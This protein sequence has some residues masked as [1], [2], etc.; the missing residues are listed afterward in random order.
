[1]F[2]PYINRFVQPDS[3]IPDLSNPQSWN[4]YSYVLNTPINASDPT[5]HRCSGDVDE[6]FDY[7]G[8]AIN[9]ANDTE[10]QNERKKQNFLFQQIF[11]GSGPNGIWTTSDWDRYYANRADFWEN[12]ELWDP[13]GP[14]GWA[15]F[16]LQ[17]ERL[18]SYYRPEQ[19]DQFVRDFGLVF[20]GIPSS[21][22]FVSAALSVRYGPSDLQHLAYTNDGLPKSLWDND[23]T[24]DQAHHYAGIFVLGYFTEPNSASFVNT[25][26]DLGNPG[27]IALGNFAAGSG[28]AYSLGGDLS[29]IGNLISA[30]PLYG[31]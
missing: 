6:C 24:L 2:S 15:L 26:R 25:M 3:I 20:A 23:P 5:G 17:A 9:G 18:S 1:L 10:I 30:V 11:K 7:D 13:E 27:D 14:T 28:W 19:Q 31:K 21:S 29:L 12:P 8:K 22:N 16:A 4:R